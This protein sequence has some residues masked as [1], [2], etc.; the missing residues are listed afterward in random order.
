MLSRAELNP[1]RPPGSLE[2]ST[3]VVSSTD[4]KLEVFRRLN[5]IGIG[6]E[7]QAIVDSALDDGTYLVKISDAMARMAL[8][9]GTKVGDTLSMIFIAKEPRPTF[10]L[11]QQGSS[12]AS[13][14]TAARLIDHLLHAAQQDGAP[15]SVDGQ[16]P[17][18]AAA[19]AFDPKQLAAAMQKSL[20]FSGLFY[21][22]HLQ[23]WLSGGRSLADIKQE[24]Q[25]RLGTG[26]SQE[27]APNLGNLDIGKLAGHLREIGLGAQHLANLISQA[28]RHPGADADLI[29]QHQL[30]PLP[31]LDPEA[32]RLINLQLNTLEH[33]QF[34]WNGEF[35]PGQPMEWEVTEE[36]NGNGQSPEEQSTWSSVVRFALPHLGDVSATIRLVGDRVHIQVDTADDDAAATLR[37]HSALL[38]DALEA[39]GSPLDSLLV[40][41]NEPA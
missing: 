33:Q 6:R 37:A 1:T 12:T 8:P 38:A 21:E 40:K 15:T 5:Q 13:L 14:S 32:A 7:M 3:P 30:A 25:A 34:R 29:S 19:G 24:P 35:W 10:L 20:G 11:T 2:S 26:A 9:V 39:A 17:L 18:L 22:S 4:P 27:L 28:Q 31:T 23:E 41:R 16:M 36:K